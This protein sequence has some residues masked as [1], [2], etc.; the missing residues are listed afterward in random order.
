MNL[1]LAQACDAC[2]QVI[3]AVAT[4]NAAAV[5]HALIWWSYAVHMRQSRQ[6]RNKRIRALETTCVVKGFCT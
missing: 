1:Q 3:D 4:A 5:L 2:S 6:Q